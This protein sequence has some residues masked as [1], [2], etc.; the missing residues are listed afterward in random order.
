[1]RFPQCAFVIRSIRLLLFA[2][3]VIAAVLGLTAQSGPPL[4][5]DLGGYRP[6][7]GLLA[8]AAGGELAISWLGERADRLSMTFALRERKPVIRMLTVQPDGGASATVLSDASPEYEITMGY[9]RAT[10]QQLNA[11]R[12][13]GTPI[14]PELVDRIKW[15]AFWDAPLQVPGSLTGHSGSTPPAD[16]VAGQPGSPR[17]PEEV[18]RVKAEFA[19]DGC[20]VRTDGARIVVTFPGVQAGLFTGHLEYT[21]YRG[22]NLIQQT[23]VASTTAPSV[24]YKYD[25]GLTGMRLTAAT[26][27]LWRSNTSGQWVDQAFGGTVNERLVPIKTSNRLIA[28]QETDAAIAAF[29]PPHRF[30][31]AREHEFNLGY[32]WHRKDAN[33]R[34]SFGIRQAEKEEPPHYAGHGAED[35]SENFTLYSARPGTLQRMPVFFYVARGTGRD[36]IDRALA[37]TRGDRYAPLPGYQVMATHFHTGLVV[38]LEEQGGLDATLPEFDLMKAAGVNIFAPI[39]GPDESGVTVPG[40]RGPLRPKDERALIGLR[41]NYQAAARHSDTSFLIMP[42]YEELTGILGGHTDFLVSRPTY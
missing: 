1:M 21:V 14:T 10:D 13:L 38:R 4:S 18:A 19:T 28:I 29:P 12:A 42:N 34:F 39:D 36:A 40:T 24:A 11:L 37:Y 35:V 15:D 32:N 41:R 33:G 17:K 8:S 23:L 5:C 27:A 26:K 16:G 6:G 31:W 9:R 22:S 20:T 2:I 25:T 3:G 7:P 30:F